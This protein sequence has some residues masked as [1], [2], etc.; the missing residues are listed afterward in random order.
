MARAQVGNRLGVPAVSGGDSKLAEITAD[1]ANSV[2]VAVA[3][4]RKFRPGMRIAFIHKTGGSLNGSFR[5]V[6]NVDYVAGVITYSG[7]DTTQT[8]GTHAVYADSTLYAGSA[9]RSMPTNIN[10]GQSLGAGFTTYGASTIDEMRARLQAISATTYSDAQLD[11]M[12][13]NDMI[14]ALRLAD[15]P[16]SV[17]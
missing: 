12:T 5:V 7:A 17:R 8:P 4:A 16:G 9:Q 13:E 2:T 15:A 10:G 1:G 14:Y 6:T 3:D 11:L